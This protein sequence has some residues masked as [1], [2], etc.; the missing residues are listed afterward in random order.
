MVLFYIIGELSSNRSDKMKNSWV[1]NVNKEAV[2]TPE[3]FGIQ[4]Q[5]EEGEAESSP[6]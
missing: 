1:N 4:E 2:V 3:L 5:P 6:R